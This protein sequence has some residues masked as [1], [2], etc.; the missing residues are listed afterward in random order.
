MLPSKMIP[1]SSPWRLITGLPEL[2]P[3]MSAVLTKLKGVER[4]SCDLRSFHIFGS[5]N[6][7]LLLCAAACSYVPPSVVAHGIFS[8][9]S[10]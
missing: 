5:S 1:T 8:P 6:G 7:S 2:P 10:V 3:M 4:L 9:P